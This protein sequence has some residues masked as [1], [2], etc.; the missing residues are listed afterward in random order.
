MALSRIP[1]ISERVKAVDL[2]VSS[3]R[4]SAG[5]VVAGKE[6]MEDFERDL[7]ASITE[8]LGKDSA[9]TPNDIRSL[10]QLSEKYGEKYT[11]Q[12]LL[13]LVKKHISNVDFI[14]AFLTALFK[15]G[16]ADRLRLGVV[17][18]LFKDILA[19]LIPD[20]ELHHQNSPDPGRYQPRFEYNKRQRLD[21]SA[22]YVSQAA[23]EKGSKVVTADNLAT[24]FLQCERLDLSHEIHQLADKITSEDPRVNSTTFE[25]LLLPLLKKIPPVIGQN[26]NNLLSNKTTTQ[27]YAQIFRTVIPS[28]ITTYVQP[29]PSKTH[30]S[31]TP[32]PRLRP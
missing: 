9:V 8:T 19:D 14:V 6:S 20:L 7:A 4:E 15:A 21:Y 25:R 16:E 22:H 13:P 1:S 32:T 10:M 17:Q 5:N 30:R 29:P 28:Y 12:V 11:F 18:N 3:Y 26:P 31:R 23:E 2:L 24:L 27:S